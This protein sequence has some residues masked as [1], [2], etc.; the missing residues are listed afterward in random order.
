MQRSAL[1]LV[2]CLLPGTRRSLLVGG[3][4]GVSSKAI[5]HPDFAEEFKGREND[6]NFPCLVK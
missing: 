5:K 4:R 6:D 1:G 2:R 3:A